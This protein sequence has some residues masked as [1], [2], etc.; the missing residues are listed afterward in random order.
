LVSAYL[1]S[2]N[3]T[4]LMNEIRQYNLDLS[5]KALDERL[6]ERL[7]LNK[8]QM[9]DSTTMIAK[10]SS[11]FLLNYDI[12][13]LEESL[14]F[15]MKKDGIKAIKI[16]D[17]IT[18]DIFIVGLKLG[19][20]I[21]FESFIPDELNQFQNIKRPINI[22]SDNS[23]DRIGY[24]TLYYDEA[25]IVKQINNLKNKTKNEIASFNKEIDI[26][27]SES[28][29]IKL[30][31]NIGT[32]I[33]ILILTA[34]LLMYFVNKPLKILQNGLDDFFLF[35]QSKT[36]NVEKIDLN[37]NDEF[38]QMAKSLND[39]II[40]STKLHEEIHE[41]NTNLEQRIEEKTMKITTL[42]NN[43]GQGFLTFDKNFIIDEEYSKECDK[44]F[45]NNLTNLDISN[46]LFNDDDKKKTFKQNIQNMLKIK[47]PIAQKSMI[48]L[49][50]QELILN[51]RA[52]KF[53]YKILEESTIMLIITNISS[54]K[55]LE[56]KVKK[57]QNI[58]KMIVTIIADTD[59][60]YDVKRDFENFVKNKNSYVSNTKTSLYNINEIYRTVHTLKGS[61]LQLFMNDTASFLHKIESRLSESL[62]SNVDIS[63][64]EILNFL[65]ETD[66]SCF[67]KNDL[68]NI[69]ELLGKKF[70]EN[71]TFVSID[72]AVIKNIENQYISLLEKTK[73]NNKF[74]TSLLNEIKYLS[75]KSL[76]SQLQGYPLLV[77][78]IAKMLEKEVYKFEIIGDDNILISDTLKPFI[79]SLIHLFRNSIDHGIETPDA[80]IELKK[81]E[82]GTISCSFND[83]NNK[84]QIIIS[85]DGAGINVNKIKEK[86]SKEIDT[87]NLSNDDICKFIFQDN[88]STKDNITEISG[89]GVG[90]SVVKTELEKLNGTIQIKSELNIGTTFV[91][92]MPLQ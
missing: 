91:F 51:K 33:I 17:N 65:N 36:D 30:Y 83:D 5:M 61:F 21:K 70:L 14:Y 88:L 69:D 54:N 34:L 90:M 3:D 73:I 77:A 66:F 37:T 26:Q 67:M 23:M 46:I 74:S 20:K 52:L 43:A 18:K 64:I 75:Q 55:K 63:N 84:L 79:K 58:L 71:D 2:K 76:K 78:Q 87:S 9:N 25:V 72:K 39:N 48:T 85:D 45:G 42:L 4:A 56:K 6:N 57:E 89:R 8:K 32:V 16:F 13:G 41:L 86:I 47:N 92:N 40:V 27:K 35:L 82:I 44:F 80:R 19:N 12:D 38:G 60:F 22:V 81:D 29:T 49:L 28:D 68:S 62:A 59:V 11:T 53:E 1:F 50:P 7:K 31:I 10:N 24:I 15:D